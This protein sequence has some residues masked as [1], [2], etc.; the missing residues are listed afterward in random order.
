MPKPI[1][2]T[3]RQ[4]NRYM[5][6]KI[7]SDSTYDRKQVVN[8]IWDNMLRL[9]GESGVSETS[10]W[11]MDWDEKKSRGIIKVNHKSVG[12]VRAGLTLVKEV[13]GKKALLQV[14]TISGTL[15][16]ARCFQ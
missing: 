15:K 8:A 11:M 5:V 6:F 2:P 16:K 12:L 10:L 4:R 3:L 14:L 1:P 13:N 7:L 9:Y